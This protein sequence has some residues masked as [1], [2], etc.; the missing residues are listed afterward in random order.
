MITKQIGRNTFLAT[1]GHNVA[2]GSTRRAAMASA[3]ALMFSAMSTTK[4]ETEE[5]K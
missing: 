2:I 4:T 5:V 1:Q 3:L